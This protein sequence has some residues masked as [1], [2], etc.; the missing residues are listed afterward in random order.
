[1]V[2]PKGK[3]RQE[4]D[5]ALAGLTTQKLIKDIRAIKKVLPEKTLVALRSMVWAVLDELY[6][7]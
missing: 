4:L 7:D 1:M 5:I 2:D 6:K 3:E